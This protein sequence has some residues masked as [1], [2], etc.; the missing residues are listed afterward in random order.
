[1]AVTISELISQKEAIRTRKSALYDVETSVGDIVCKLPDAALVAESWDMTS[2]AEGNKNLVYQCCIE[3]NLKDRELH[4]AFGVAEP[5][6]VVEAIF[7]PG[8]IAKIAGHLLKLA[9]FNG[10][11]T[12]KLHDAIKN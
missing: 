1:M 5:F 7:M 12:S 2:N 8:E 3:P 10:N 4:K 9:G 6:D 11:V